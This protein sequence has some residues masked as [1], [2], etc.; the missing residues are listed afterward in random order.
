MELSGRSLEVLKLLAN[1]GRQDDMAK[2]LC[3]SPDTFAH[4]VGDV[5]DNLGAIN[6]SHAVYLGYHRG[7]LEWRA[8][9]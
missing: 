6:S 5:L 8:S 2:V 1:G 4:Q 7:I 3:I 9:W